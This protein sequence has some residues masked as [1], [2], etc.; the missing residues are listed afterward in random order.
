MGD[1]T[2]IQWAD[3]TFNPWIGCTKISPGCKN[4]Y[5]A[6][7]TYVR[8]QRSQGRE[9][10]R[11]GGTRHITSAS[12]WRRPIAWDRAAKEAG[13]R[14]RVFCASMADVFESH[15]DLVAPRARLY[16]LIHATPN[17][18]W[19]LL[20]KR[21][22]EANQQWA[23]AA[24]RAG[25]F[26]PG[27]WGRNVWLGVSVENQKN[28]EQRV[29]ELLRIPV[30]VR[31]VSAEPLLGP[32]D[33]STWMPQWLCPLG[34]EPRAFYADGTGLAVCGDCGAGACPAQGLDW[35]IVGGES[36]RGARITEVEHLRSIVR[37]CHL[38][39][40]PCFVKQLGSVPQLSKAVHGPLHNPITQGSEIQLR[41]RFLVTEDSK[42]GNPA[43]W[44]EDLRVREY[45]QAAP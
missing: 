37:Q 12:Y 25:L 36:G 1:T 7:E 33:L 45:P 22:W 21:P 5:A 23:G 18:D 13:V 15:P 26:S 3:H 16:A 20:T 27:W 43:E 2:R 4:C 19:L 8:V 40:V 28:A 10:W 30:A 35:V 32:V 9:L 41:R 29:P 44:P 24:Q 17:L 38:A 39:N 14:A 11:P 42:G 6:V 34:H 31:F